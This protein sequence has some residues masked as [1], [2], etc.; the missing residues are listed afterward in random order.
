MY[1]GLVI[2]S[3]TPR[4]LAIP[5]AKQVFPAPRGPFRATMLPFW[6]RGARPFPRAKVSS[7]DK[8]VKEAGRLIGEFSVLIQAADEAL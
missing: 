7:G 2:S 1:V 8:L 5:F 6:S 3:A 4:A